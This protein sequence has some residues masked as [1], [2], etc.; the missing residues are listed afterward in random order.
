VRD[1][2]DPALD[3]LH[4]CAWLVLERADGRILL[5]RRSGVHYGEGLWGLPGGHAEAAE[6]WV[7]A[8]VRDTREEVG[9]DVRPGD[10]EPVGVQRYRDGD[11]HGVDVFF[12]TR[13]WSGTPAAVSECSEVG[14]FAPGE[15]P[16]DSLDWLADVLAQHLTRGE[17]FGEQ[18]FPAAAEEDT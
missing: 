1:P 3:G 5:G 9:V 13:R 7:A 12:R 6:S 4:L 17:W 16:A 10:L 15:L 8:A 2:G 18:G 14:W 11:A